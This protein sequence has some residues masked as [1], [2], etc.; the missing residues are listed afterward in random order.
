MHRTLF[1]FIIFY[2]ILS[3]SSQ[4]F[5]IILTDDQDLLLKSLKPLK[6]IDKLLSAQGAIFTNA[7]STC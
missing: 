6:K 3:I 4:N 2:N 5:V 1:V 7:V